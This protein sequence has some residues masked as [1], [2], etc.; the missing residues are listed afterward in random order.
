MSNKMIDLSSKLYSKIHINTLFVEA[1]FIGIISEIFTSL[2]IEIHSTYDI[3]VN[4]N[5]ALLYL[6]LNKSEL[7]SSYPYKEL[8]FTILTVGSLQ[9][10]VYHITKDW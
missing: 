4:N 3:V 8:F 10:I 9:R 2:L 6:S 7:V 5:T 1:L